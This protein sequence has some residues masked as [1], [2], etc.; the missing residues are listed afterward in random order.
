M[1]VVC[2]GGIGQYSMTVTKV[3][4]Q[5]EYKFDPRGGSTDILITPNIQRSF[6]TLSIS[7]SCLASLPLG[8]QHN[9]RAISVQVLALWPAVVVKAPVFSLRVVGC[10]HASTA[11]AITQAIPLMALPSSPV[12]HCV[13]PVVV[14]RWRRSHTRPRSTTITMKVTTAWH[15]NRHAHRHDK[16]ILYNILLLSKRY[17]HVFS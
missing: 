7:L 6:Y 16:T 17:A 12:A 9:V 15:A 8:A 4:P 14:P 10:T 3:L 5:W 2:V 11:I 13:S 1:S